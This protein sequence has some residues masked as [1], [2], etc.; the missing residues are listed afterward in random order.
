[1][2]STPRITTPADHPIIRLKTSSVLFG[3][4][5]GSSLSPADN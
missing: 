2:T 3:E 5:A 4:S 1:L